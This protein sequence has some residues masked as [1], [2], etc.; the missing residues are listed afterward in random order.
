MFL[1]GWYG[2]Q[3]PILAAGLYLGIGMGGFFDGIVFHQLMQLHNMVSHLVFPDT[4]VRA[5]INMFWDGIFHAFCYLMV[6]IGIAL[7]FRAARRNDVVWSQGV[8]VGALLTGAGCFN[9]VEGL[10]DHQLLQI[11]HVL[12]R[13]PPRAQLGAD[14]AFLA[15]GVVLIGLGRHFCGLHAQKS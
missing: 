7:L 14:L 1:P 10:I 6:S 13:A 4:L 9:F 2:P 5:E 8:F 12:E 15:S 11:H 3:R